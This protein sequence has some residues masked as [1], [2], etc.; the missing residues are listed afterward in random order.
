MEALEPEIIYEDDEMLAVNKPAGLLVHAVNP[1]DGPTLVDW[2]LKKYPSLAEVGEPFLAQQ[3]TS[4]RAGIAHRLD[5]ETSGIML[6]AKN[7]ESFNYLKNLF[8]THQIKKTYLALVYGVMKEDKGVIDAPIGRSKQD[9]R[10]RLA[11]KQAKGVLRPAVT[12]YQ[13]LERFP[14]YSYVALFPK[15]GRT[16][17]LRVHLQ[18]IGRP[19]V[20]D[21]LY[22]AGQPAQE[23]IARQALHASSVEFALSSGGKLKLEAAIP[24]DF[25]AAL[26]HLRGL[27]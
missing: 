13:T 27:C 14:G 7:N 15:T 18:S 8:Q 21:G 6:V 19:V 24:A 4:P 20:G 1:T 5:R 12:E 22:A 25:A 10:R 2:L 11:G 3:H 23:F 16:H 9:P 26:E 17:Q